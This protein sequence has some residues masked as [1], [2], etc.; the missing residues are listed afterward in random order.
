M[1]TTDSIKNALTEKKANAVNP[2]NNSV[3]GLLDNPMIQNKFKQILKEKSAQF[4]S[5]LLTLVNNDS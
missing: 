1:A 4:T 2:T 3:K 5:S